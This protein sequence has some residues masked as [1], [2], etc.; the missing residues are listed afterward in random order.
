[1]ICI[2]EYDTPVALVPCGHAACQQCWLAA[3]RHGR[4]AECPQCRSPVDLVIRLHL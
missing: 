4:G 1:M 2:N 3:T